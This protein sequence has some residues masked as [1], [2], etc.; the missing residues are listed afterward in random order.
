MSKPQWFAF[1]PADFWADVAG[2]IPMEW[3]GGYLSLICYAYEHEGLLPADELALRR[4]S[5]MLPALWSEAKEELLAFFIPVYD[6]NPSPGLT[7][8]PSGHPL[9]QDRGLIG[10]RHK[11]IDVE[12]A[13]Q[14][15]I[16]AERANAARAMHEK[17]K[18]HTKPMQTPA[19]DALLQEPA[20]QTDAFARNQDANAC[21]DKTIQNTYPPSLREAPLE[22]GHVANEGEGEKVCCPSPGLTASPLSHPLPKRKPQAQALVPHETV[23]EAQPEKPPRNERVSH[24]PPN[25]EATPGLLEYHQAHGHGDEAV[26]RQRIERFKAWAKRNAKRYTKDGW[27]QTFKNALR[28]GW[29]CV[30]IGGLN[31]SGLAPPRQPRH[32]DFIKSSTVT[33]FK[34]LTL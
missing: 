2:R 15:G 8:M 10:Y 19:P 18:T 22:G 11:R 27:P 12:L 28:E 20:L 30:Q 5:R 32:A 16:S 13:K 29:S 14:A 33:E 21:Y 34:T 31:G 17:R 23:L 4:A 24:I 26:Y 25:F 1:N 7:A 6:E 9:P 3:V